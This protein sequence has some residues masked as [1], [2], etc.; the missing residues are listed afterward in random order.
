MPAAG[1]H[2]FIDAAPEQVALTAWSVVMAYT[3]AVLCY[4]LGSLPDD[5]VSALSWCGAVCLMAAAMF[6]GLIKFGQR[7]APPLIPLVNLD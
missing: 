4:Q 6:V 1:G 3:C 7:H 5:P 2:P